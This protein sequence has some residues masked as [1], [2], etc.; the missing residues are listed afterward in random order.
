MDSRNE[1]S[2]TDVDTSIT[3]YSAFDEFIRMI[4]RSGNNSICLHCLVGQEEEATP[5]LHI[6]LE[7]YNHLGLLAQDPNTYET[8]CIAV[9]LTCESEGPKLVAAIQQSKPGILKESDPITGVEVL[10]A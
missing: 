8:S 3:A 6:R 4:N 5:D 7:R 2:H 9:K 10:P 1:N